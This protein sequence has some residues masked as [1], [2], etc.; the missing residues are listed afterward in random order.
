MPSEQTPLRHPAPDVQARGVQPVLVAYSA[1]APA[2]SHKPF[3]RHTGEPLSL[4]WF[5]GSVPA[6]TAAQVPSLA[7]VC[8]ALHAMQVPVQLVLQQMPSTQNPLAQVAASVHT[9]PKV[10]SVKISACSNRV[11]LFS[12][13][14]EM[15]TEPS[16][17][18]LLCRNWPA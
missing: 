17:S 2:P 18:T 15:R 13:P 11:T 10:K 3:S 9:V 6:V 14:P 7:P 5:R 1:Q 16:F 12:T 8:A 4:H